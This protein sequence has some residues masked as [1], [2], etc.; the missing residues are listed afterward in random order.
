MEQLRS[1]AL[2]RSGLVE[3]DILSLIEERSLARKNGEFSR[4]DQIRSD[5]ERKG[6]ALMDVG[7]E[8][9]WRPCVSAEEQDTT[10]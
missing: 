2:I 4:S 9:I 8:T 5:L 7:K 1:K 6:V 3:E 10:N